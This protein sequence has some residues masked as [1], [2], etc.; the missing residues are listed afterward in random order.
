L[1]AFW[2]SFICSNSNKNRRFKRYWRVQKP[3]NIVYNT[4][5][6]W[7]WTKLERSKKRS[8]KIGRFRRPSLPVY[9]RNRIYI[10]L[11][12]TDFSHDEYEK[13]LRNI[14][15][16]PFHQRPPLGTS[17]SYISDE[18]KPIIQTRHHFSTVRDAIKNGKATSK[19]ALTDYLAKLIN[20]F[21]DFYI[22][23][24]DGTPL[25][26]TIIK[27][28][29]D[30]K[31]YRDEFIELV[32][33]ICKYST[34]NEYFEKIFEF[35]EN[36]LQ[37]KPI[38]NAADN[39]LFIRRELFIYV[40]AILIRNKKYDETSLFLDEPYY[41][42]TNS[43]GSYTTYTQFHG[44]FTT[45]DEDRKRRL[46]LNRTSIT[47]DLIKDRADSQFVT[48]EELV[49]TD[50]ILCIRDI[51]SGSARWFP[52]TLVYARDQEYSGFEIFSRAQNK[53]YFETV[54][55]LL[56][57]NDKDDLLKRYNTAFIKHN[58][59]RWTF[60]GLPIRFSGYMNLDKLAT[61]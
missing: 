24:I 9:L 30:F 46:G 57:V 40:I 55:G 36:S 20:A 26:E 16:K 34:N 31:P 11:S 7:I 21:S 15:E 17:P 38:F 54:K 13:L 61:I 42:I 22:Q 47:A 48:F 6:H 56:K 29:I 32:D 52:R 45:I 39:F 33:I 49:Q 5:S 19:G 10:L 25:D 18:D 58:L 43:G 53:R 28:I 3:G 4:D 14:Y 44:Y 35:L 37:I 51:L 41:Y 50:F 23:P 60:G 8:R 1:A 27:S 2:A 12:K 59:N